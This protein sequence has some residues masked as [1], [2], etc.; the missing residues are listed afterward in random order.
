[1]DYLLDTI[2]ALIR[3]PTYQFPDRGLHSE[4]DATLEDYSVPPERTLHF[5]RGEKNSHDNIQ[6]LFK[7]VASEVPSM[8]AASPSGSNTPRSS[9]AECVPSKPPEPL[10]ESDFQLFAYKT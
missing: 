1:M 3:I 8:S 4:P 5:G 10:L 7:T 9:T 6:S 2:P